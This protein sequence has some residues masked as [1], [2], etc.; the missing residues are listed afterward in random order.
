MDEISPR[1]ASAAVDG[2]GREE[3]ASA[4]LSWLHEYVCVGVNY[5]IAGGRVTIV[6]VM[7]KRGY[8]IVTCACFLSRI[9]LLPPWLS[10][11]GWCCG[12]EEE[13]VSRGWGRGLL[14]LRLLVCL[15]SCCCLCVD[16]RADRERQVHTQVLRSVD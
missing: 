9:I 8:I 1:P 4:S 6:Y 15:P 16:E 13:A 2:F 11:L 3:T 14:M 5:N 7:N 12:S 10:K